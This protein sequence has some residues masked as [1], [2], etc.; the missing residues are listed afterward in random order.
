MLPVATHVQACDVHCTLG[1]ISQFCDAHS[2]PRLLIWP[3][4]LFGPISFVPVF[5]VAMSFD[6]IFIVRIFLIVISL[7]HNRVMELDIFQGIVA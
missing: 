6:S 2:L 4:L 3:L 1:K 7:S 5:F